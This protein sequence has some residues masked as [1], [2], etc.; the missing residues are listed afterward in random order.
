M[1]DPREYGVHDSADVRPTAGPAD[2]DY[3][4]ICEFADMVY[5]RDDDLRGRRRE[6]FHRAAC[7]FLGWDRWFTVIGDDEYTATADEYEGKHS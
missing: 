5:A 3:S 7:E 6:A 1:I 2:F 4:E